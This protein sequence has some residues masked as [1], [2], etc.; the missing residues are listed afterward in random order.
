M[1]EV[2]DETVMPNLDGYEQDVTVFGTLISKLDFGD[3][4]YLHTSDTSGTPLINMKLKGTENYKVWSCAMEL[5]LE[6]KNKIGFIN[7][8]CERPYDNEIL[9]KQW[10]RCNYV[11]LTWILNS[12]SEE[13]YLGQI[14][15]RNAATVWL[16]LKET[17]D[18]VDG[19]VI[20]NLHHKINSLTQ[21]G[22]PISDYYHKLNSL[23]KQYDSL[24]RLPTCVCN[25]SADIKTYNQNLKLM[26]F[27]MGLDDAYIPVRSQL[28]IRDPLPT[29]KAAFAIISREES[30]RGITSVETS[31]KPQN[32][33]F[34]A[35]FSERKKF[36]ANK[37]HENKFFEMRR[38]PNPNLKCTRCDKIGHTYP[39]AFNNN[40]FSNNGFSRKTPQF[41]YVKNYS[42]NQTSS[43]IEP[44]GGTVSQFGS[45]SAGGTFSPN[46]QFTD[47][48]VS[49]ILKMLNENSLSKQ[50][51]TNMAGMFNVED[52]STLDLTVGHPNGTK[53]RVTKIGNLKLTKYITLFGVLVVPEYRDLITK[54]TLGTG[55]QSNGLYLFDECESG[56]ITATCYNT[57]SMCYISKHVWHC[58]LGHP[59]NQKGIIHQTSCAY[60]PQ[61]NGVVERKHIHLLNV[62]RALM[63]QGGL[64][65]NM[66][67]ECVLTACYLIN[68][69]PSSVLNGK[70]PYELFFKSQPNLS[71]FKVFGCLCFATILNNFDKFSSKS[72][73]CILLGYA[74]A[75]K[76]YK[77]LSIEHN[78]ILYYRDVKFYENIFHFKLKGN[79]KVT[80]D[81]DM[82]N[83]NPFDSSLFENQDIPNTHTPYDEMRDP[84]NGDGIANNHDDSHPLVTHDQVH[85]G[86][87]N[88]TANATMQNHM[89]KM[90]LLREIMN[91]QMFLVLMVMF[92]LY[93]E[94][95]IGP[96]RLQPNLMIL[97]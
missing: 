60:S 53:A 63:F 1:A 77:L 3:P 79:N 62:A 22:S 16:E 5:A 73:K 36:P 97:C 13:V 72:E 66:W 32:S 56:K 75:K 21:N 78:N 28:L 71:H 68:R 69:L 47:E 57:I 39:N 65:L 26:Q 15:S 80:S 87:P 40:K 11:V 94:G 74:N 30:H 38:G 48:H 92:H 19:S 85:S 49:Q 10:D 43:H 67:N 4:L 6:T 27:L 93:Q 95:P 86:S 90:I 91:F 54:K 41:P 52:V 9:A 82:F 24:T 64:P 8:E 50:P 25:A 12:M 46:L 2:L 96:S 33:A 81:S 51:Q 20:F 34:S 61:Q 17:Y 58:I 84:E 89:M 42:S 37:T 18:K 7:G 76:R 45:N 29:V 14:F 70:S 35:K 31:Q 55:R 23:W 88:L 44:Q 59:A 83:K